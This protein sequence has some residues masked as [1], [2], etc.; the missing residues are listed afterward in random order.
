LP[1][2]DTE[3][4]ERCRRGNADAFEELYRTHAGRVFGL[5][6]RMLADREDAEDLLQEVFLVAYRRLDT[7]KD[8]AALSTC[9]HHIAVNR[10]VDHMRSRGAKMADASTTLEAWHQPCG[11]GAGSESRAVSSLDLERAIRELPD[12]YRAAFVLRDVEGLEHREVATALGIAVGTSKSQA[13][14]ATSASRDG[15]H[16]NCRFR[17]FLPRVIMSGIWAHLARGSIERQRR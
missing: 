8:D 7:F 5:V 17:F 15:S 9:L 4:I 1:S 11:L 12:G 3:L 10:S 6:Y 14:A 16:C 2:T 13:S